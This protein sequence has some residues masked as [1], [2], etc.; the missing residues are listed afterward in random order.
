MST[1]VL[2]RARHCLNSRCNSSMTCCGTRRLPSSDCAPAF[3]GT[4]ASARRDSRRASLPSIQLLFP[5]MHEVS[6]ALPCPRRTLPTIVSSSRRTWRTIRVLHRQ[7]HHWL[8]FW[9]WGRHLPTLGLM[10]TTLA[11]AAFPASSGRFL[12]YARTP[13][14]ILPNFCPPL[15]GMRP[16]P[17]VTFC[18]IFVQSSI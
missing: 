10:Q 2:N 4:A 17:L 11:F 8:L 5:Q 14:C 9:P 7:E 18:F 16:E 13:C 15:G 6:E 12:S 3:G 1:K